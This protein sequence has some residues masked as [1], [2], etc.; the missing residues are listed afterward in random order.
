MRF[1]LA[2]ALAL[3]LT[4]VPSRFE[5]G[6]WRG[7]T[8]EEEKTL[9]VR[10]LPVTVGHIP[11][12]A[13]RV[14]LLS[15]AATAGCTGDVRLD[16]IRVHLYGLGDA[17]ALEGLYLLR[18]YQRLTRA[19][20]VSSADQTVLLRPRA[21]TIPACETWRLDTAAD[22][23]ATTDVGSQ[24]R[25]EVWS[26]QD[27]EAQGA[28]VQ[29]RFPLRS[30]DRA[31]VTP[32]PEGSITVTFHPVSGTV[33]VVTEDTLAK[34][35]I[36]ADSE[37]HQLLQAITLTNAGTATWDKVR[38]LYLTRNRGRALTNTVARLQ[39]DE[40]TLTFFEPYFLRRGQSVT[41][42]LRG[43]AFT[44]DETINFVLK[45]PSDLQA[46]STRRAGRRFE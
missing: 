10:A 7:T 40:V 31:R 1:L 44:R 46:Q 35:T 41:F 13:Q 19:A 27:I 28:R 38:N 37:A 3:A 34:F 39:D 43:R 14:R 25:L 22:F 21:L 17:S 8:E 42:E 4:F 11:R 2:P 23:A 36:E 20:K 16:S 15:L 45:E 33:R 12:G 32:L 29:G 30:E 24:Y 5:G 18:G 9:E 6:A 26:T